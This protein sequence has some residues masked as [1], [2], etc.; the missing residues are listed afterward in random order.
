M[1][2]YDE[3]RAIR[4]IRSLPDDVKLHLSH[5]VRNGMCTVLASY[6]LG[7]DVEESI[8]EFESRWGEL[9]L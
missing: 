3:D 4:T 5:V 9:D 6:R 1:T 2:L 7:L 8:R